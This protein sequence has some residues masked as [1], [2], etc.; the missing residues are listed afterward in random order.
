MSELQKLSVPANF[1]SCKNGQEGWSFFIGMGWR[2]YTCSLLVGRLRLVRHPQNGEVQFLS[3]MA[4]WVVA[5]LSQLPKIDRQLTQTKK[6]TRN[7]DPPLSIGEWVCER[8][9]VQHRPEEDS[10]LQMIFQRRLVREREGL[11]QAGLHG[12]LNEY[13][14]RDE[15][16]KQRAKR[17][18][19]VGHMPL[20]LPP[21]VE[22]RRRARGEDPKAFKADMLAAYREHGRQRLSPSKAGRHPQPPYG[23]RVFDLPLLTSEPEAAVAIGLPLIQEG[24]FTT[25]ATVE[26]LK[27]HLVTDLGVPPAL[28][29]K[30]W[31]RL[32]L[33]YSDSQ[34]PLSLKAYL[35][36]V[37]DDLTHP[38]KGGVFRDE[39]G[40][41][42]VPIAQ[43]V[44]E[45]RE[46]R[47]FKNI[48][49]VTIHRWINAGTL[50][51]KVFSYQGRSGAQKM[52]RAVAFAD[53]ERVKRTHDFDEDLVK[54]LEKARKIP[55]D[56]AK[57]AYRHICKGLGIK[58]G[59]LT[60]SE[61]EK[62][63]IQ[64]ALRA[65]PKVVRLWGRQRSRTVQRDG[66]AEAEDGR[67]EAIW[68]EIR[69]GHLRLSDAS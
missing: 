62:G 57:R 17:V 58:A 29:D 49:K 56:S 37:I 24:I 31:K 32:K 4:A 14:R 48:N 47:K 27:T 1:Y 55:R 12:D 68:A 66:R 65:D 39:S 23:D 52:V 46:C 33:H 25:K 7:F 21:E 45:L 26:C 15:L 64:A 22:E 60:K 54:L 41:E 19:L 36:R 8:R 40:E 42:Y 6:T 3:E 30:V 51:A 16:L 11:R 2:V 50:I 61:A 9:V 59:A 18:R 53:I 34:Y 43:A 69:E 67:E 13:H 28:V 5:T 38:R 35:R 20:K 44:M 63:H 10:H